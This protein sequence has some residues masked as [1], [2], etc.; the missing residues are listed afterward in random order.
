MAGKPPRRR[1]N[2]LSKAASRDTIAA[3]ILFQV[4]KRHAA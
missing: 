3:V 2:R 4:S 1:G